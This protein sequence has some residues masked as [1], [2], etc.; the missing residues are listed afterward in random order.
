M[1]PFSALDPEAVRA[2]VAE[3]NLAPYRAGQ[4]LRWFYRSPAESFAAMS[5]LPP[6]L[7]ASLAE[8][9][10]FSTLDPLQ[11]LPADGGATQKYLFRLEGNALLESVCMHYPR[12]DRSSERTT[13]CLSSQ[14][15]C[16]VGCP[17][18]A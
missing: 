9:F 5:S 16:A 17:F 7:R 10:V 18:C 6:A 15:G 3:R 8:D 11:I 13:L 1:T 4:V 14:V 12:T 2:W